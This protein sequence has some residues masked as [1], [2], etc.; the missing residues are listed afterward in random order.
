VRAAF[1][2]V[3]V[4]WFPATDV[5]MT[6]DAGAVVT[7]VDVTGVEDVGVG[8]G[9]VTVVGEVSDTT[10][11]CFFVLAPHAA[12][13]EASTTAPTQDGLLHEP[14]HGQAS[15]ICPTPYSY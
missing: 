5:V 8:A 3:V 11:G 13:T 15:T 10:T 14:R 9:D 4:F 2:V 1:A 6:V 7:G 12:S